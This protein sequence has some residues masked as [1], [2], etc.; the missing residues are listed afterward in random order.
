MRQPL[1]G[2]GKTLAQRELAQ[3]RIEQRLERMRQRSAEQFDGVAVD[4]LAQQRAGTVPPQRGELVELAVGLGNL[5]NTELAQRFRQRRRLSGAEPPVGQPVM[6]ARQAVRIVE[7][8]GDHGRHPE[9]QQVP[10]VFVG[11]RAQYADQRQVGRRPRLVEPLLADRPP[12]VMCQPRQMGVQDEGEKSGNRL[13]H[14]RTA[15][16]TRSRLSSI[17]RSPASVRSKSSA[18]TDATSAKQLFG[19]RRIGQRAG[20]LCVDDRAAV[21]GVQLGECAAVEDALHGFEPE[22]GGLKQV[23]HFA[24][25]ELAGVERVDRRIAAGGEGH[26]VGR[27]HQQN[28]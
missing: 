9:R 18:V 28:A 20:D 24:R 19:P 27:R 1:V 21:L 10:A 17:S 7:L 16:A 3:S 26:P 12:T 13:C 5:A 8:R 14:G 4:Q 15:I 6:H 22:A 25:V 11:E 23:G 2:V